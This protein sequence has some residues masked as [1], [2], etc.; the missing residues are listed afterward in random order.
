VDG[1][2]VQGGTMLSENLAH[3]IALIVTEKKYG[4]GHTRKILQFELDRHLRERTQETVEE[5]PADALRESTIY[6]LP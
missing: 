3:Y 6:P 4:V 5:H 2:N 1:A